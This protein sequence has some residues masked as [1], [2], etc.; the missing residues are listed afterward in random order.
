MGFLLTRSV[1]FLAA[2]TVVEAAI[3]FAAVYVF[4][5]GM[6]SIEY[7]NEESAYRLAQAHS[8]LTR[9]ADHIRY[10]LGLARTV[11]Q[12]LLPDREQSGNRGGR[13]LLRCS[14]DG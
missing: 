2:A 7:D 12:K 5:R 8:K 1:A 6:G 11:Q 10:D 3:L 9:Y 4:M 13:G 14:C